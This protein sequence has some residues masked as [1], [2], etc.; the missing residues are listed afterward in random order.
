MAELTP[1][2]RLQPALLD[3]LADDDPENQALE[4]PEQRVMSKARLRESV[5]RD[6]AWLFNASNHGGRLGPLASR[7]VINFGLTALAGETAS[8]I[9]KVD[10]ERSIRNA[11][12]VFEPRIVKGSLGVEAVVSEDQIDHHNVVSIHISGSLWA[13]PFPLEFLLRTSVDLETGEV[14]IEDMGGGR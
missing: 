9:D 14:E 4:P 6:L 11:I 3:R 10:L 8:T 2:E 12:E 7:S 13:Q 1:Q 5:L